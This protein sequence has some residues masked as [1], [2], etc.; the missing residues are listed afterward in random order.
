MRKYI[1]WIAL[2]SG[3]YIAFAISMFPAAT[4]LRWFA[5]DQLRTA[6]VAGTVWSGSASFASVPGLALRDLTWRI[7]GFKL[8]VGRV[9][10]TL[11]TRLAAGFLNAE[12][13]ISPGTTRLN[14]VQL[15]T[16][17][18]ALSGLLPVSGA[19]GS[20]SASLD[21]LVLEDNWPTSALGEVR[22]SDLLVEPFAGLGS[23]LI[24]L[25][26][27]QIDF[28]PTANDELSA[29]IRD[30]GGPLQV[31]GGLKLFPSREYVLEGQVV[32]R[33]NA[34]AELTQGISL[35]TSEPD[36]EGRRSFSLT[37]SL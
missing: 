3:A 36:A 19:S 25:G 4:A 26:N 21:E 13:S 28:E 6:N 16:S 31:A 1:P 2:A 35:M 37:G 20:M 8:L 5:P 24:A 11:E 22:V 12:F 18:A 23:G 15:S 33:P 34:Q 29:S 17:L 9:A 10:G 30:L 14:Q 32:T 27:Y 7:A